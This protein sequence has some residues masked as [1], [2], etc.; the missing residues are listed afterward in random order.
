[1][2][3]LLLRFVA[4]ALSSP[5]GLAA[6]SRPIA[7]PPRPPDNTPHA[8]QFVSVDKDVKLE[9]LDWGG[10]GRPLIFLA[11]LGFDAHVYDSFAPKF[12]AAYHVYGITRRGFGA[13]TA[14]PP[15]CRN[16]SADRLGDDVLAVMEALN[17]ERPVLIGHSLGGEELSSVGTRYP[18]RLAGLIYLDAGYGYAYYD[19]SASDG[20]PSVDTSV[21]RRE[22]EELISPVS[23]PEHR[24]Q[25]EHVLN[26]TIPRVQR[27]LQKVDKQLQEVPDDKPMP[28]MPPSIQYAV[29]IQRSVQSYTGVKCPTLAIFA[30]P[31]KLPEQGMTSEAHAARIA[32][33]LA[34][35]GAQ[36]DAFQKG[37]PSARVIRLPNADH[38]VFRSNEEDVLREMN[39]FL[40]TLP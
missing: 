36:A 4:I 9:V 30:L 12:V 11:G 6:Q 29:A 2:Q 28:P 34:Q 23:P 21:L 10:H 40:A 3:S 16:Y 27:D 35:T 14:P 1:M 38:F 26:V 20:D 25:I 7:Q 13:S 18:N 19:V 15:D 22:L 37:N 5:V 32:E 17:I 33:D 24:A 8:I 39:A 31:H